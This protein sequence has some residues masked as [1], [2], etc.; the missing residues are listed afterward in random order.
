MEVDN[1]NDVYAW[2]V[3]QIIKGQQITKDS[4]HEDSTSFEEK[5]LTLHY[6]GYNKDARKI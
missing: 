1:T 6:S 2:V 3:I 5:Y 4:P